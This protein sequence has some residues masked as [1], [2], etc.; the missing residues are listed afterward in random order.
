M[1]ILFT[2]GGSGGHFYPIIAVA[3][4]INQMIASNKLAPVEMFYMSDSSYNEGV[5]FEN[6]IQF[7]KTSA[8]KIRIYFS[9]KNFF[10]LFKTG[11]GIIGAIIQIYKIYPD[12]IFGKGGYASFP[13][14]FAARIFRI[15]VVLHESDSVPGRVNVWASKFADR[16]AVSYKETLELFPKDKVAYTGNPIRKEIII[17]L[18]SGAHEFFELDHAIPTILILGGSQGAQLINESIM[19]ALPDLVKHYQ[20]IH[21]TGKNNILAA[22]ETAAIV[23]EKSEFKSRYKPFDYL[24]ILVLRMAAGAAQIVITRAGSTLF[25]VASW[26]VPAIVVPI[27]NTN[28]NHQRKNAYAYA[29]S[30]AGIVIEEKN[31]TGHILVSEVTR[32]LS[33]PDLLARMKESTKTFAHNDAAK[34]IA[35]EIMNIALSHEK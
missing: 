6:N 15:P 7:K 32:L 10:D 30:G 34:K 5:L 4:E 1:K 11:W 27:T 28:G 14:L 33:S 9:I 3:E 12:V 24:Q 13:A 19:E 21:Q 31:L 2:G 18:T 20:V 17:P 29:R 22:K 35:V 8:G 26:G 23:L 16:I 25:E